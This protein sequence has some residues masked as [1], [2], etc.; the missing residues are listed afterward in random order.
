MEDN[1]KKFNKLTIFKAI[2][3]IG[4]V[5]LIIIGL[6]PPRISTEETGL[7]ISGLYGDLYQW[8]DISEVSLLSQMPVIG[9]RT[10]GM[11]LGP[12]LRGHFQVK[13]YGDS[14]LQINQN[15]PAFVS[16]KY[17]NKFIFVSFKSSDAAKAI[18]D[19]LVEKT[20]H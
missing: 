7:K 2:I 8:A 1:Q 17:Q 13:E 19:T 6:M 18:Y 3:L 9:T 20:S 5:I 11:D 14:L 10:N 4:V 16:F 15:H 12:V